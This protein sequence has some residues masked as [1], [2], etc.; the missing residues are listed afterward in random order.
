MPSQGPN[1]GWTRTS[2]GQHVGFLIKT[3][4]DD[5]SWR[6]GKDVGMVG[7][8]MSINHLHMAFEWDMLLQSGKFSINIPADHTFLVTLVT[9]PHYQA[10]RWQEFWRPQHGPQHRLPIHASNFEASERRFEP[11][12]KWRGMQTK[13]IKIC[14]HFILTNS[15]N[16]VRKT[17]EQKSEIGFLQ[18]CYA[19]RPATNK[20]TS[21][22]GGEKCSNPPL[23]RHI[24]RNA[25]NQSS[26]SSS[27]FSRNSGGCK[28]SWHPRY[29]AQCKNWHKNV[30]KSSSL[31]VAQY[32]KIIHTN[33]QI[34]F[35]LEFVGGFLGSSGWH[36][37]KRMPVRAVWKLE[38]KRPI[39]NGDVFRWMNELQLELSW[40]KPKDYDCTSALNMQ[41]DTKT[42]PKWPI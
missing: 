5:T 12:I 7:L 21:Q 36:N 6:F 23:S 4:C 27:D 3:C 18:L 17:E 1:S 33:I 30:S 39:W 16:D 9:S 26:S 19:T 13:K 42:W 14:G 29:H 38:A 11:T 41:D 10:L 25:G 2:S 35:H 34:Q 37:S 32:I 22:N 20:K 28:R 31:K 40:R 24:F 8:S 15:Y